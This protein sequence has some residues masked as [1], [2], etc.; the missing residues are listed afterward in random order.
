MKCSLLTLS[1]ALDGELSRERQTELDAHLITCERCRTGMRYLRE[2]TER[3]SLLTP[4]HLSEDRA[5]ALLERARVLVPVNGHLPTSGSHPSGDESKAEPRVAPDPFGAMGLEAAIMDVPPR[6]EPVAPAAPP[7]T[8][9]LAIESEA[10]EPELEHGSA[11]QASEADRAAADAIAAVPDSL[12]L[13]ETTD[14]D[15]EATSSDQALEPVEADEPPTT[16]A[17]ESPPLMPT[18]PPRQPD[19]SNPPPARPSSMG[20]DA[21]PEAR[22]RT[23]V[24]PGWEPATELNM[25]WTDIPPAAPS[26]NTWA[27]DLAGVPVQRPSSMPPPAP[28]PAPPPP[29]RP[30]AAA[31]PVTPTQPRTRI[32]ER[33]AR[34]RPSRPGFTWPSLSLPNLSLDSLPLG[35]RIRWPRFPQSGSDRPGERSWTRTGL[36][37]VAALA[38]VLIA[39][40]IAHASPKPAPSHHSR[41]PA[42]AAAS[43]APSPSASATP[44]P[45]PATPAPLALSG[46]QTVGGAGDGYVIQTVRYGVHGSQFWVVFQ[47]VRGSGSPKVTSGLDG[48]LTLYLEMP[49]VAPGTAVPQPPAGAVV[50]SITLGSVPGFSGAVYILHLT[51]AVQLSPS[52]LPG[53]NTGGAGERYVAILQ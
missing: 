8:E 39:W 11:F 21:A 35:D 30:A 13:P 51:R 38:A 16:L 2:E 32:P 9:E 37:A 34:A 19:A 53:T 6:V 1:C 49:G 45:T 5:T 46:V 26:A 28:F 40:N 4:V 23:M 10:P 14:D 7:D 12:W 18:E 24:I 44:T 27:P 52:L 33:Q 15:E 50:S 29:T 36:I 43:P 17:A 22:P 42:A 31:V 47:M 48:P 20:Q 3:I 25:P 41:K